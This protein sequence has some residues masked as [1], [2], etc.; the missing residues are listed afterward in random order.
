MAK[1]V[2]GDRV[3]SKDSDNKV[4]FGEVSSGFF[5]RDLDGNPPHRNQ[6]PVQWDDGTATYI[7]SDVLDYDYSVQAT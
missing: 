5:Y 6:V 1:F 4:R 3:V 7:Y 2:I